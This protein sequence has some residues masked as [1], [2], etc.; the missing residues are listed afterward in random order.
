MAMRRVG[1]QAVILAAGVCLG[2]PARAATSPITDA[3]VAATTPAYEALRRA[4]A[5]AL[6]ARGAR[7]QRFA[8]E[9]DASQSAASGA[10]LAWEQAQIRADKAAAQTPTIDGLG[11]LLYPFDA[12]VFPLNVHGNAVVDAYRAT[13]AQL[14]ALQG[15]EFEALFR[16]R[17]GAILR[18]LIE[19]YIDYIKNGDDPGLRLLA[20]RNLP[21]ARRLLAELDRS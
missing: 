1:L 7:L 19:S 14:S 11:P 18:R 13:L 3:F 21:R 20:V 4:D 15:A 9:D 16:E 8:R 5:L 12:V 6:A 10:L 17:Q 2:W